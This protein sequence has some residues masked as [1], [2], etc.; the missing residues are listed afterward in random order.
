MGSAGEGRYGA[1]MGVMGWALGQGE[2]WSCCALAVFTAVFLSLGFFVYLLVAVAGWADPGCGAN[3]SGRW[4]TELPGLGLA[5]LTVGGQGSDAL[6]I[7][8]Y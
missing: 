7:I 1:P 2:P 5:G 3:P 6:F 8:T 4:V